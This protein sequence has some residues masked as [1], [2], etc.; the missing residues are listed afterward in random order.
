[1]A[2]SRDP[3]LLPEAIRLSKDPEASVREQA[4]NMLAIFKAPESEKARPVLRELL[5]DPEPRVR[6]Q[7]ATELA[8][9]GDKAAGKALVGL[10]REGKM[11]DYESAIVEG[12]NTLAGTYYGYDKSKRPSEPPNPAALDKFDA[13]LDDK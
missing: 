3:S 8:R 6:F 2:E 7:A 12:L 4:A 5:K 13:W 1:L 9:R 11:K 10:L